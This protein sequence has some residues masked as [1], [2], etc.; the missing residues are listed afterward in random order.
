MADAPEIDGLVYFD[1][2]I[3]LKAGSFADVLIERADEHD[4]HGRLA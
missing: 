3:K 4:L 2:S 1:K